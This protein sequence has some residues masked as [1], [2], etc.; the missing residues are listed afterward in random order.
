MESRR[1]FLHQRGVVEAGGTEKGRSASRWIGRFK[2]VGGLGGPVWD[3]HQVVTPRSDEEGHSP[4]N[5]L[6]PCSRE[7]PLAEMLCCP[8]RK[9]TQV[10]EENI[11]RR[12]RD[13][14]S[15]NSAKFNR[16][17]GIRLALV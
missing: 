7:K 3:K 5:W 13:P 15:R 12:L 4:A 8:Y 10:G 1:I 6:S 2:L 16:N 14:W 17:L 11:L 9:P